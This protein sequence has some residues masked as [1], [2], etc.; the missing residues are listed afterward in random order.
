M[1][2]LQPLVGNL[3]V[4][5]AAHLLRRAAFGG[6]R[7]EIDAFANMSVSQAVTALLDFPGIPAPPQDPGSGQ[8]FNSNG[9]I[10]VFEPEIVS[11]WIYHAVNPNVAPTAFHKLVFFMHTCV[12]VSWEVVREP[13][14]W[15]YHKNWMMTFAD[16]SYRELMQKMS[17]DMAMGRFLNLDTS[18]KNAPNENYARELL[19]LFTVGKGPQIGPSNYTNYTEDDIRTIAKVFTGFNTNWWYDNSSYW[20]SDYG[21]PV[22]VADPSEHDISDKT[23][24]AAFNNA[25]ISGRSSRSG[26]FDEVNELI[27]VIFAQEATSE[28]LVRKLYRYYVHYQITPEIEQDIIQPLAQT[29]RNS[30]FHWEPVLTQLLNSRH[31][32]DADDATPDDDV[33]GGLIK[34]PFELWAQNM[35][36]F[37]SYIPNLDNDRSGIQSWI[38]GYQWKLQELGMYVW[39]P[40]SVA[41][42]EPMYQEPDFNRYW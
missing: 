30:D 27:D 13:T 12:T 24:S 39:A 16:K 17:V 6:S 1:A 40:P 36:Y 5:R 2:S 9:S 8:S 26:M 15:W 38:Y 4:R 37:G 21:H 3:G 42:Y 29:F 23:L 28:F 14:W 25:T 34:T 10:T 35:R 18:T 11:W 7:A 41:G 31:F 33:I 19:E 20:D 22:L 32:Y